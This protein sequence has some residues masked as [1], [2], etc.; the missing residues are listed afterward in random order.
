MDIIKK[1]WILVLGAM[2]LVLLLMLGYLT[3]PEKVEE[4]VESKYPSHGVPI[5]EINLNG[6]TQEEINAGS[7]KIK[8]P[9]NNV[10]IYDNGKLSE[11][12]DVEVKGRG[13]ATWTWDKRPY[14][15]KFSEKTDILGM[16]KEKKWCLLANYRDETNLRTLT[17]FTLEKMLGMDYTMD[18]RFVELY[19]DDNYQGLYY[20]TKAVEVSSNVVDLEDPL[21]VLV[22]LDNLYGKREDTYY[23]TG[24]KDIL[25]V[26]DMVEEK[27]EEEAMESFLKDYNKLEKAIKE[28]DYDLIQELIDVESF[29]QY[30]L[31]S[32]FTV[33]PDAYWTSFY[34]HKDGEEDK[35]HAGPGWDFD[36][37]FANRYWSNWLGDKLYSPTET[38]IRKTE[39]SPKTWVEMGYKESEFVEDKRFSKIMFNLVEIP[40]FQTEIERVFRNQ[41]MGRG[42]DLIDGIIGQATIIYRAALLDTEKWEKD[43][44][45]NHTEALIQWIKARYNYFEQVYGDWQNFELLV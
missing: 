35:I 16:G 34:M 38:M 43:D 11:Y 3:K 18:G 40:E 42:Q 20:L 29:A 7:K 23:I 4:G 31:L 5:M 1:R 26:K 14:Q 28:K 22:E 32:E 41:M 36:M 9:G 15:I 44:F 39:L 33:N 24:N 13:N 8:Y 21:G 25:T 2:I 17:G 45:I 30:Y 27:N 6:V 19:F 37:A 12:N 10:N